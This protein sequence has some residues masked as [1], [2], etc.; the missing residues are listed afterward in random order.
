[1]HKGLAALLAALVVAAGSIIGWRYLNSPEEGPRPTVSTAMHGADAA[2]PARPADQIIVPE[3]SSI[4]RL[5]E[6]VFLEKC[7]AC[8][9]VNAAGTD[10]GPPFVHPIYKPGHHADAAFMMAAK[11]GV[12]AHHWGFGNMPPVKDV[13]DKQIAWITRY[14]RE[15]QA[16]NGIN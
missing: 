5:G 10:K 15:I 16:A 13:T 7:A 8:H 2:Q 9:G 1:M 14:V 3:L 4:A 11:G 12:Q 6:A